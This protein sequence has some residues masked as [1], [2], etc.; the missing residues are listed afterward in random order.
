MDKYINNSAQRL[1]Y[2]FEG[3]EQ[4]SIG[5]WQ[6]LALG[7]CL[8]SNADVLIFDEPNASLDLSSEKE[9]LTA[10]QEKSE[11]H[12]SIFIM[13]RFNPVVLHANKI[14]V[15]KNGVIEQIGTHTELKSKD[16]IYRDFITNRRKSEEW[17][18]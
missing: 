8:F 3:G 14:I 15:L 12:I 9:I 13:H 18:V 4:I 11:E 6:K 5:Q 10:L 17:V 2:Q 16:G 7:R 1:G